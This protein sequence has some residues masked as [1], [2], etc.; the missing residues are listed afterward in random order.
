MQLGRGRQLFHEAK[1]EK[2]QIA[3]LTMRA[4]IWTLLHELG[5]L[6][7]MDPPQW[8]KFSRSRINHA[9]LCTS[10]TLYK[11]FFGGSVPSLFRSTTEF[12]AAVEGCLTDAA[13]R[14]KELDVLRI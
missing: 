13:E 7:T 9:I 11:K 4:T 8:S 3:V 5:M 12:M 10:K 14:L 2:T 1:S 6:K